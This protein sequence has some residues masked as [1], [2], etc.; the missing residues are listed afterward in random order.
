VRVP[1]G[2]LMQYINDGTA[3]GYGV[4]RR[5]FHFDG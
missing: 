4:G 2:A 5:L 3:S 1:P